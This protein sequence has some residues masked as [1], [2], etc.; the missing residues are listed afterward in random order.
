MSEIL[1]ELCTSSRPGVLGAELNVRCVF[2][3][4]LQSCFER[5]LVLIGGCASSHCATVCDR[6]NS[7][8]A[9]SKAAAFIKEKSR[10]K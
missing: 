7:D 3:A 4:K 2:H 8:N 5:I 10:C 6:S 9:T 1:F